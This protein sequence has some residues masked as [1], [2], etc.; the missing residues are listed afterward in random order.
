[1]KTGVQW[2]YLREVCSAP[3]RSATAMES[4]FVLTQVDHGVSALASLFGPHHIADFL[5]ATLAAVRT[6]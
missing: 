6:I 3:Y 4:C 5:V 2:V 1:M